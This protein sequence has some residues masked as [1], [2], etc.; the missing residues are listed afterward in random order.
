MALYLAMG[1]SGA[2]KDTLLLGARAALAAAGDASVQFITRHLT[3]AASDCTDIE[4]SVTHEEF[5]REQAQGEVRLDPSLHSRALLITPAE[6]LGLR[7]TPSRGTH[8]I[9]GMRFQ[10][11]RSRRPSIA[12]LAAS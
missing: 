9:R 5:E 4:H 1:P 2:G 8:T 7:S 6:R 3:R 11:V 10:R 12:T